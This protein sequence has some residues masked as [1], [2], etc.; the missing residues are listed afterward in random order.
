[1]KKLPESNSVF[2]LRNVESVICGRLKSP[3]FTQTKLNESFTV[4]RTVKREIL[5]EQEVPDA[6][7]NAVALR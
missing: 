2:E 4:K 6:I 1:M 3:R 5:V 7:K